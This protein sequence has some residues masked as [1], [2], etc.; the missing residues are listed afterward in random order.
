VA[1]LAILRA[2]GDPEDVEIVLDNALELHGEARALATTVAIELARD[3]AALVEQLLRD[4][5]AD[6]VAAA[7]KTGAE[8]CCIDE[9]ALVGAL[10][11][12]SEAK[13]AAAIRFAVSA[14]NRDE[15]E[16]LLND[17]TGGETYYYDVVAAFDRAVYAPAP[18][19]RTEGWDE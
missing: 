1:A 11:D 9:S 14:K 7:F 4:D 3:K 8:Y 10:L 6:V 13:R 15:L 2:H 19:D 12:S 16:Q 17:Y 5:S 18:W